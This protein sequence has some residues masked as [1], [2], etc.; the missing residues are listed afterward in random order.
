MKVLFSCVSENGPDWYRRVETRTLS[1]REFGGALADSDVVINFVNAVDPEFER[2]LR[3]LGAEVRVVPRFDER[4]VY[5]NKLR[6]FELSREREFDVLL[7]LDCDVVVVG[8]LTPV[9]S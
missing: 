1:I 7:G 5:A 2:K 9:L 3:E 6:M 4:S 8:D